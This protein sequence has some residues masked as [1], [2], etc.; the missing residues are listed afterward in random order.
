MKV[1]K[2]ELS[3]SKL[4]LEIELSNEEI[5]PYLEKAAEKLSQQSKI[6]GFRPGKAP[7]NVV[8]GQFGEMKIY[9]AAL[10]SIIGHG[11][12]EAVK[13]ENLQTVGQPEIKV[14]KMAPGNPIVF[15]AIVELMPS[16][17]LGDWKTLSVKRN[18]VTVTKEDIAKTMEQLQQMQTQ[19]SVVE[20]AAQNG[21]KLEIDFTVTIDKVVIEGGT[22]YKYPVIIG[23][24]NM[25]PGFEEQLI[26][27][28]AKDQKEFS[29]QFP[30]KYFQ[31]NVAGKIADFSVKVVAVYER[32][33]PE[34]ND[35]FAKKL[36]FDSMT[37]LQEQLEKNILSDKEYKE[38]QRLENETIKVLI[39]Q[40]SFGEISK[41]LLDNEIHK[42]IH[43]LEHSLKQQGMDMATYL[44]SMGKNHDD[45]HKDFEQQA[46]NR[47][48]AALALRSLSQAEKV[49]VS[50]EDI[51]AELKKQKD[52][53]QN[54]PDAL[55]NLAH[56][57]YR[58][59]LANMLTNEKTI[60]LLKD[61]IVK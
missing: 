27:L 23:Q 41:T 14:Q 16:V 22:S 2:K 31:K 54:S 28:K 51:E 26:G 46:K 38:E 18:P 60:K 56:P 45:L 9:E 40:A 15:E 55:K 47:V 5:G 24:K 36:G 57:E 20:R 50:E 43:E 34:L 4:S 53:Y 32:K 8:K 61:I 39:E 21:D 42:M 48:K 44:K 58:S 52:S 37:K 6:A 59:Y 13:S 30:D 19:E 49:Q 29:L 7:F 33:A 3:A 17:S 12:F 35:D 11:F 1:T 25:I 10:E